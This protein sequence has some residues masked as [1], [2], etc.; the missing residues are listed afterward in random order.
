MKYF[1]DRLNPDQFV[2]I[3]R[4]YIANVAFINKLEPYS[5]DTFI[6]VF[7]NGA[8]LNVSNTGYKTLKERLSF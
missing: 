7:K 2:R 5:K 8:K 6:A 1:E 3:H 4:S